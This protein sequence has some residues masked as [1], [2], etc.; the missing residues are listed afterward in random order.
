MRTG[1]VGE[2]KLILSDAIWFSVDIEISRT[3]SV[4]IGPTRTAIDS[5]KVSM[6]DLHGVHVARCLD[7]TDL[8]NC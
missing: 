2:V 5:K 3:E 1:L 4:A 8:G 7:Y 6:S